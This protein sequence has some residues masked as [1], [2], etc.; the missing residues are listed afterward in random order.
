MNQ[1][2]YDKFLH[3]FT[4]LKKQLGDKE[5]KKFNLEFLKRAA[6]RMNSFS[7][8]CETCEKHMEELAI[9]VEYL[10]TKSDFLEKQ[11]QKEYQRRVNDIVTH[12]TKAHKL[13]TEGHYLSIGIA[14]GLCFGL[15]FGQ[16]LFDNLSLG[17]PIGM[18]IGLAMGSGMDADAKKKGLV[19]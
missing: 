3:D 2:I 12:L 11:D 8:T 18:C 7:N 14:L 9:F 6:V 1:N 10:S 13:V 15:V 17:M 19:I 5:V 4:V 16:T